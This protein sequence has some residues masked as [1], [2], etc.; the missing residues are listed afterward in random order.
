MKLMEETNQSGQ[1]LWQI[2]Q[3]LPDVIPG[4]GQD[5]RMH[6]PLP[7]DLH[8]EH[9][10]GFGEAPW[11][12]CGSEPLTLHRLWGSQRAGSRAGGS[13][14][15]RSPPAHPCCP[16]HAQGQVWAVPAVAARAECGCCSQ[17][18]AALRLGRTRGSQG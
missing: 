8:P 18:G 7:Q 4:M 2:Q 10:G 17:R 15:A 16:P 13:V 11:S 6:Q 5:L 12:C 14:P 9:G 3:L 1:F